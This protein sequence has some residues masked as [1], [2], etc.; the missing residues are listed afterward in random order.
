[1]EKKSPDPARVPFPDQGVS[2]DETTEDEFSSAL[3][4]TSY[5]VGEAVRLNLEKIISKICEVLISEES[6][7][8]KIGRIK[9]LLLQRKIHPTSDT[10]LSDLENDAEKTFIKSLLAHPYPVSE[11]VKNVTRRLDDIRNGLNYIADIIR[12]QDTESSKID[13]IT[14]L[15]L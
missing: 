5:R 10:L 1:M 8:N 2:I 12:S 11:M 7:Q 4:V 13:K 9:I 15:L 14:N 3:L 6:D